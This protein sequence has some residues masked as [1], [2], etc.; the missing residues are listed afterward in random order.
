MALGLGPPPR[1]GGLE[2]TTLRRGDARDVVH[3]G[4]GRPFAAAEAP[5]AVCSREEDIAPGIDVTLPA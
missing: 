2:P 1:R 5:I 4:R 3:P